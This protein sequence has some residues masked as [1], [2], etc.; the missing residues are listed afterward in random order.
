MKSTLKIGD[1]AEARFV[2]DSSHVI[3]FA[4][5][6]MP[7]VL[8]TPCLVG[9]LERAARNVL[10]P[11]LEP[12]ESSVGVQIEVQHTAPTPPGHEVVCRARVIH[13]EGRIITFQIEAFDALER[14]ARGLHKR[15]VLNKERFA[16][17]VARKVRHSK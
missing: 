9:F 14:V 8:S 6:Q 16:V 12:E 17:R 13:V 11:L 3:D 5:E 2:V 10:A 4:D 1:Q 7:A 15:S